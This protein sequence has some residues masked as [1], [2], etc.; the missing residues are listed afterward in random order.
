MENWI[1]F[2]L[3]EFS[4]YMLLENWCPA[5]S[6]NLLV[7]FKVTNYMNISVTLFL[8]FIFYCLICNESFVD[9]VENPSLV[10]RG[11]FVGVN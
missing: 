5:T 3:K 11:V 9:I 1:N 4:F 6:E 10:D 8:K 2:F 7:M